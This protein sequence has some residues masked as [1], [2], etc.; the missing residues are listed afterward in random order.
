MMNLMQMLQTLKAR[1]AAGERGAAAVEY[2]LL[3]SLIAVAIAA[4]VLAL[5]GAL[6]DTFKSVTD[7][8]KN[9]AS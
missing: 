5:G 1:I 3:V 7:S 6:D 8:I 2:A 9:V 4:T